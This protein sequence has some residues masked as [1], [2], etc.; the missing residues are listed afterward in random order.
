MK[1]PTFNSFGIAIFLSVKM[2]FTRYR[3]GVG[4]EK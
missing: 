3:R 1:D 2:L 4:R